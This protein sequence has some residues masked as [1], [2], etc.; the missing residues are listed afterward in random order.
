MIEPHE[1]FRRKGADLYIEK[2]I[3]LRDALVGFHFEIK[4]LDGRPLTVATLPGEVISAGTA[5]RLGD[6]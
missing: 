4:Q 3:P 2:T 1:T 6:A 5:T